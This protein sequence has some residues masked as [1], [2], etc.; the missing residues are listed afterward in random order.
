MLLM[1]IN[2]V[3]DFFNNILICLSDESDIISSSNID[4][5]NIYKQNSSQNLN[6]IDNCNLNNYNSN[7]I[8]TVSTNS[9]S[10]KESIKRIENGYDSENFILKDINS[11]SDLNNI[12]LDNN[13]INQF[14]KKRKNKG[15]ISESDISCS[16]SELTDGSTL[17]L[18][19]KIMISYNLNSNN[20]IDKYKEKNRQ[21]LKDFLKNINEDNTNTREVSFEQLLESP[22][23]A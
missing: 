23:S 5:P 7:Y 13:I 9:N 4:I 20:E 11:D 14:M 18:K 3:S 12:E 17:K 19:K 8:E 6:N 1:V 10:I 15:N 16:E 2:A 22:Q 21:I